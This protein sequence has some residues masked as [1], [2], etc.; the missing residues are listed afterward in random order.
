M[1][2]AGRG[3]YERRLAA[4]AALVGR[5]LDFLAERLTDRDPV[6]RAYALRVLVRCPS[7]TRRSRRRTRTPRPTRGSG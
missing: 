3:T 6:V 4:F 2:L 1:E 5:Q 7:P